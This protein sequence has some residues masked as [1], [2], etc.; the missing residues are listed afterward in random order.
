MAGFGLVVAM[1]SKN[2]FKAKTKGGGEIA[3][4]DLDA[5]AT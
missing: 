1:A 2:S 3:R 5:G 4:L